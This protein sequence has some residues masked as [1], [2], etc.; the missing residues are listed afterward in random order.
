MW[1]CS[2]PTC[3]SSS[4]VS[5]QSPRIPCEEAACSRMIFEGHF[6]Q[7]PPPASALC[8]EA[9]SNQAPRLR[10]PAPG[11]HPGQLNMDSRSRRGQFISLCTRYHRLWLAVYLIGRP[12]PEYAT[13]HVT[14]VPRMRGR[15]QS[16]INWSPRLRAFLFQDPTPFISRWLSSGTRPKFP[17]RKALGA[18]FSSRWAFVWRAG[19]WIAC[20]S[21]CRYMLKRCLL[22]YQL[23]TW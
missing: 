10:I 13:S 21:A 20:A 1:E 3:S 8:S 9:S 7:P 22:P 6:A 15:R 16:S 23:M 19:S 14:V 12:R 11:V 2:R 18:E 4:T 17:L 5:L